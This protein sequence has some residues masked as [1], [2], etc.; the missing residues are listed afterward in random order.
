MGGKGGLIRTAPPKTVEIPAFSEI[1]DLLSITPLPNVITDEMGALMSDSGA[2]TVEGTAGD[3]SVSTDECNE[4]LEGIWKAKQGRAGQD[5]DGE[6][7]TSRPTPELKVEG[8][9]AHEKAGGEERGV[10]LSRGEA[11]EVA[12]DG[13]DTMRRHGDISHGVDG[14][15]NASEIS[16]DLSSR[17]S[18]EMRRIDKVKNAV[19]TVCVNIRDAS[20]DTLGRVTA[21]FGGGLS[22]LGRLAEKYYDET[23]SGNLKANRSAS[24]YAK[25]ITQLLT[26][27]DI[28]IGLM[29]SREELRLVLRGLSH[30][31]MELV[32]KNQES[33]AEYGSGCLVQGIAKL[34]AAV[35]KTGDC[36]RAIRRLCLPIRTAHT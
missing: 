25:C 29:E 3:V 21:T 23:A 30:L 34:L 26:A 16:S 10:D 11:M 19:K 7:S 18:R 20:N 8:E 31:I 9:Q 1:P 36:Q 17:R 35:Q 15:L 13:N 24:V 14:E 2:K 4:R 5:D 6:S 22:L 27:M 33:F 32:G 12:V 28:K